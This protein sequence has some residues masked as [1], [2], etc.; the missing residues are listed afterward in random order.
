MIDFGF[1]KQYKEVTKK[2]EEV[3]EQVKQANEFWVNSILTT[4]KAF[5]TTKK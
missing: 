5:Y 4:Y 3:V 1:D 2:M